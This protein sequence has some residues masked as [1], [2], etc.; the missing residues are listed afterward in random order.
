[1]ARV[2]PEKLIHHS[3]PYLSDGVFQGE[4]MSPRLN[5]IGKKFHKLFVFD[6][7]CA[8]NQKT[9]WKCLCDCGKEVTVAGSYLTSN[10]TRS[11]GCIVGK[12]HITHNESYRKG[13]GCS[14]EYSIWISMINRCNNPKNASYKRYGARGILVSK[15]WHCYEKF[16]LDMGRCPSG[17]YSLD[18]ID[19]SKGYSKEN[20]RWATAKE[21]AR[22]RSSTMMATAF[23][24][25]KAVAEW[26]EIYKIKYY[27]LRKRIIAGLPVEEAL[28]RPIISKQERQSNA[29]Q[30]LQT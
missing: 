12:S 16:L 4:E 22:N 26:A 21:Q 10:G 11:C 2:A 29:E 17:L 15:D 24:Q 6:F 18:R 14:K 9:Y 5:L 30:M 25:T 27:T 28:T 13:R 3:L 7:D 19:N 1:M 20:C 8:K 23:G